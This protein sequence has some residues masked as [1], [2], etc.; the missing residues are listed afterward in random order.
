MKDFGKKTLALLSRKGI[1]IVGSQAIPGFEG[2]R[3]FSGVA[4]NLCWNGKGFLRTHSQVIV[5]AK[6]SWDPAIDL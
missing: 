1:S 2:D 3:Y 6:S 4:Y 5:L